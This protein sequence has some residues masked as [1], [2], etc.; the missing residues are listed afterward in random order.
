MPPVI[1][2]NNGDDIKVLEDK[3]K[4]LGLEANCTQIYQRKMQKC[5]MT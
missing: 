2:K 3:D 1:H 5:Q 4:K